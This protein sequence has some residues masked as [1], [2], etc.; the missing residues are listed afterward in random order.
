MKCLVLVALAAT[1]CGRIG[2]DGPHGTTR[3]EPSSYQPGDRFGQ[4]IAMSADGNTLA[5]AASTS[6]LAG[7]DSGGVFVFRRGGVTWTEEAFLVA[8]E[9]DAN[10]ELAHGVALSADG[11]TL[12]VGAP[13][14][15][16][17][18]ASAT[19]DSLMDSGA[20][21]VF[22]RRGSTWTQ[23]AYLKRSVP[24][25]LD[26]LGYAVALSATG[27]RLAVVIAAADAGAIDTGA[28]VLFERTGEVWSPGPELAPAV[29]ESNGGFGRSC[30][31][32][33]D[34]KTLA[35]A[36]DNAD[37]LR[38][39]LHV[40]TESGGAWSE[41]VVPSP[42]TPVGTLFSYSV[43]L[44]ARGDVLVTSAPREDGSAPQ[45]GA[46]YVFERGGGAWVQRARLIASD[47][48]AN[49]TLGFNVALDAAGD[50][51]L[52]GV[53]NDSHAGTL[54]GAARVFDR[55]G[56]SWE[57]TMYLVAPEPRANDVF[58]DSVALSA[59]GSIIAIGG[60]GL[61]GVYVFR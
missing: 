56:A 43:A 20:A 23:Q 48:L 14:E 19:D 28:I 33:A 4:A 29:P 11:N 44:S 51:V 32:S 45:S 30:A 57:Q 38:G 41:D 59:D 18:G 52:V 40:F 60:R 24:A 6:D 7:T 12:V 15:D 3:I 35:V 9:P 17:S 26:Y 16:S 47:A 36:A 50:R 54:S 53:E 13:F 22:A 25:A 58:G 31:F 1:G 8:A 55:V 21:Y 39:L 27:D 37:A 49:E 10:D 34:G 5:V 61:G 42:G 2:F 46:A